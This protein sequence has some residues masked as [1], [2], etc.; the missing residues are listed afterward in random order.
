MDVDQGN[1]L[2]THTRNWMMPA[3]SFLVFF[4]FPYPSRFRH[5][6]RRTN[7]NSCECDTRRIHFTYFVKDSSSSSC[8]S[9]RIPGAIFENRVLCHLTYD[10]AADQYTNMYIVHAHNKNSPRFSPMPAQY[11][12]F[13]VFFPSEE[14]SLSFSYICVAWTIHWSH[15]IEAKSAYEKFNRKAAAQRRKKI[16]ARKKG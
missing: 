12:H 11:I 7:A 15:S 5:S 16:I 6:S 3:R 1:R 4:R 13:V 2:S 14:S 10:S 8:F 9:W